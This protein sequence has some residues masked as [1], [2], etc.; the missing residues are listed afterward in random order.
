MILAMLNIIVTGV[1]IIVI[2]SIDI[3]VN[4]STKRVVSLRIQIII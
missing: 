4:Y 3:K 1:M 2:D